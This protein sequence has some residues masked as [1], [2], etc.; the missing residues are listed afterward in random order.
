M[1]VAMPQKEYTKIKPKILLNNS[2]KTRDPQ[3]IPDYAELQVS[4]NFSFLTG[5]S[6]P[7]ELVSK[8]S[9]LGT[10]AIA[11]TDYNSLAGVVRGH[12]TAKNY[13]VQ[14]IVGTRL[15][16]EIPEAT[17]SLLAYPTNRKSYGQLC[18]LLTVGKKHVTKDLISL[19]LE[20]FFAYQA[21][22]VTIIIPPYLTHDYER[23][24]NFSF[25][26]ACAKLREN[27]SDT[28]FVSLIINKT[29]SN[30][31]SKRLVKTMEL[32]KKLSIAS[33]VTNDV[34]FHEPQRQRLQQILTCIKNKTTIEKAG[35]TLFQNGER[36]LK[37]P[38]EMWRLFR[39]HPNALRRS[40]DI[41][42][43]CSYFSLDELRYE[44]PNEICPEGIAPNVYLRSLVEE[45][46]KER[47][48][49]QISIKVA[50]AVKE[51][52]KLI[53]E[54][55]YEKYF[56]TCFDIVRFARKQKI[57]CQGR[58]A[59][60]NSVVCFVLGITSVD[61]TKVDLLF[62]RFV[63]KERTEPPDIDIDF[64]HE[65]RE[66]VIQYIYNK[67]GRDYA[68]ITGG[69]VT[70]RQRSAIREVGKA[71]GMSA[72]VVEKLAKSIHHWTSSEIMKSE[73]RALKLEEED[74]T[75][76]NVLALSNEI[77]GF[78]RHLTQHVGGFIICK[79]PLC[80]TVPIVNA[81]MDGRTIIE[82]D[83]DDIETLGILKIDVLA[84]GMLT[85]IR[86]AFE[87]INARREKEGQSVVALY[88]VPAEDVATYQMISR[89]DTVGVFQVESR[90]QMSML[91]RLKPKTF[92]D[93]VIQVAIVR[94][95][96]ISGDMVHPYLKRRNGLEKPNYPD[97]RVESILG[98]TLGIPLF[99][100][101]AMRLAIVLAGFSP[102]EA[103]QLR[104]AMAAW[105]RNEGV[106]AAFKTRIVKGMLD[107]GYTLQFAETCMKQL[108]GF[109]EY[110]FPESHAAS[111]ALITYASCWIKCHYPAEFL[112]AILN[113]QP[114]GFYNPAQLITDAKAHS[115]SVMGMDINQSSFDCSMESLRSVRIG[116]RYAKGV[117]KEQINIICNDRERNGKFDSILSL[118]HRC[119]G[120][121]LHKSTLIL[122]A[123]SDS[124]NSLNLNSR[125]AL[126]NIQSFVP[127]PSPIEILGL[128]NNERQIPLPFQSTKEKMFQDYGQTGFSLKAHPI[129]FIRNQLGQAGVSTAA[130]LQTMQLA[131]YKPLVSIA[132]LAVIRQRPGTAKGVCFITIEDE[133]G[134]ANLVLKPEIF[135][136]YSKEAMMSTSLIASGGLDRIGKMV[137]VQVET[138]RSLD[139][140]VLE[141]SRV[142]LAS[143]SHSY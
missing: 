72:E 90:A 132:G 1:G 29:Y 65:R 133:T 18:R 54:L 129:Q 45:G 96:P 55:E 41:A 79:N 50:D 20:D 61:P 105:K 9:E 15:E 76:Q 92:Y 112:C 87:L 82:W 37:T 104:R 103:E 49:D 137:Y 51:E 42:G 33:V 86:K 6:H 57:L 115:I 127:D 34:H 31:A 98:K 44:Y 71:L 130:S 5:A 85:C 140:I 19:K 59:A 74:P 28:D 25:E 30:D 47:Y 108:K 60:A 39:E 116:L 80:E 121:G 4:S 102:G 77:L 43:M 17:F 143:R 100:E 27:A 53:E 21:D 67:F 62:A 134:M 66:E 70:Y 2:L 81:G 113:S 101:Q 10:R 56:L 124:F 109:A 73:L 107:N 97:K 106:I 52:L 78:P 95:G 64:E 89:A 99:Q 94:P 75:F 35:F 123:K 12:S 68:G 139:H 93:L 69:I 138:L 23:A 22:L 3:R 38:Q 126:F 91:P 16:L 8:A 122:L 13:P 83:K 128:S 110:G 141:N 40:L 58:G 63:S 24:E 11:I 125:E 120:Q 117:K 135:E 111:F 32:S 14:Y 114:M 84:L 46:L 48:G 142:H 136:K 26:S 118:W 7:E 119:Y 88:S 36:Y 131:T